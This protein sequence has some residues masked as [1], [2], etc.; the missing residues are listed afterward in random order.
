MLNSMH[1]SSSRFV[2]GNGSYCFYCLASLPSASFGARFSPLR[3]MEGAGTKEIQS[4]YIS[5]ESIF[6]L[7]GVVI[8]LEVCELGALSGPLPWGIVAKGPLQ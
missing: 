7:H 1:Y 8:K 6:I 4:D 2:L 5:G 3:C